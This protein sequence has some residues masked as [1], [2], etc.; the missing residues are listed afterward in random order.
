MV[1]WQSFSTGWVSVLSSCCSNGSCWLLL[2]ILWFTIA[3]MISFV[4]FVDG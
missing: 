3:Q 1:I 4:E 2:E